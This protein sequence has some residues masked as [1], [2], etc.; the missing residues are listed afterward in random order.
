MF[1]KAGHTQGFLAHGSG[2]VPLD[3]GRGG[4]LHWAIL[5]RPRTSGQTPHVT[6]HIEHLFVR[7]L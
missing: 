7:H 6:P 3:S 1:L 2:V 4:H 5:D